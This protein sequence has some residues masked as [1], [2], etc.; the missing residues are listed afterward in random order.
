MESIRQKQLASD[1][2]RIM[3]SLFQTNFSDLMDGAFVTVSS[4]SLSPD[5]LI[6]RINVSVLQ[7]EKEEVVL[8]N[9]MENKSRIRGAL[10]QQVKNL[11][12]IPEIQ[13]YID[14]SLEDVFEIERL[15]KEGAV[16]RD[17][18]E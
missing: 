16:N 4:V 7:K 1:I 6:A 17:S 15:L 3:S 11:R 12:R 18:E 9:L 10:G 8:N 5:L 2:Q 13:F 14:T